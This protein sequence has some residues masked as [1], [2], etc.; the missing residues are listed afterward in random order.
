M[1]KLLINFLIILTA[2]A[3]LIFGAAFVMQS[4]QYDLI[5]ETVAFFSPILLPP[6]KLANPPEVIKAVYVTAN[7]ANSQKYLN[8]L[9][10][11][12]KDTQMNSAVVDFKGLRNPIELVKWLHQ[13]NIYV[14]ARITV[15]QDSEYAKVR[16]DLAIYDEKLTTDRKNPILWADN[17]GHLWLDPASK[18]VWDYNIKLADEAFFD[19]FDEVNFDYIRFP[20]DGSEDT[21]GFPFWDTKTPKVNIIK[22][23]FVYLRENLKGEK[24]SAD[25]FGQ[26]T[27]DTDGLGIG[28]LLENAF[29]NFDY[30]SPM[31]YPSH[32]AQ[33]FLGFQNPAEYPYEIV[34]YS[35]QTAQQRRN[36]FLVENSKITQSLTG[37]PTEPVE[38][39][40][41]A[42]SL[43]KFRPWLQDFNIGAIYTSDMVK[44][45]IQAVKDA[46]GDN[47]K[48]F[49]LWNPGNIYTKDAIKNSP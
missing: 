6:E 30:I 7:S 41:G 4:K 1:A 47:Y 46:L 32:Y 20:S 25:L 5:N 19:G 12:F 22:N 24:I 16:S 34:K 36:I 17:G 15:F 45:E 42:L 35:M 13:K 37:G 3:V 40:T 11:L 21:M 26:I 48:G 28:Q 23:F 39:I 18:E 38:P 8:Y 43:A 49:M 33:N 9:G 27:T 2:L 14:I 29:E 31:V 44:Q 10:E